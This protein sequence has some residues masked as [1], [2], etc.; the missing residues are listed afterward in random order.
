MTASGPLQEPVEL[1]L[2]DPAEFE[3]DLGGFMTMLDEISS[4]QD[5]LRDAWVAEGVLISWA[6]AHPGT[7]G[8]CAVYRPSETESVDFEVV[9]TSE[10]DFVFDDPWLSCRDLEAPPVEGNRATCRGPLGRSFLLRAGGDHPDGFMGGSTLVADLQEGDV[11]EIVLRPE[12]T[13]D[14]IDAENLEE[15]H[16][17]P[18]LLALEEE[19]SAEARAQI[20]KWLRRPE[21]WAADR[22]E[23]D[24]SLED[25]RNLIRESDELIDELMG[26][27]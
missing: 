21:Q 18:L 13:E 16:N 22:A 11:V 20:K 4:Q 14:I 5:A 27:D 8:R 23:F 19:I 12:A 3:S 17:E 25:S 10:D 1:E 7:L 9:L 15:L 6:D 24:Q 26:R 2:P